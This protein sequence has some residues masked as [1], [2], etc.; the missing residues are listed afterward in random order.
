MGNATNADASFGQPG[1]GT[2][3]QALWIHSRNSGHRR[4][5]RCSHAHSQLCDV[6]DDMT[7]LNLLLKQAK[8]AVC[9]VRGACYFSDTHAV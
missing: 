1:D 5:K 2:L 3:M 9:W 7:L 4:R 6:S 8:A